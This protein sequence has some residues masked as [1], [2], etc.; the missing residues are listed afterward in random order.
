M[1]ELARG[2]VGESLLVKE[3]ADAP[4]VQ[5]ER[6]DREATPRALERCSVI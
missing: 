6:A 2:S 5:I 3:P 1:K 4:S